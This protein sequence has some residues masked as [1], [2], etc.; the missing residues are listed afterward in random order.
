MRQAVVILTPFLERM[1]SLYQAGNDVF[2]KTQQNVAY[3]YPRRKFSL[4]LPSSFPSQYHCGSQASV[5]QSLTLTNR[6][7]PQ[8][9]PYD[10]NSSLTI[11]DPVLPP[12][13][14]EENE[15]CSLNDPTVTGTDQR[16]SL[17]YDEGLTPSV[18][19]D[20]EVTP[21]ILNEPE[22]TPFTLNDHGVTPCMLTESEYH[23]QTYPAVTPC[24]PNRLQLTPS[25]LKLPESNSV[26]PHSS[27]A[28]HIYANTHVVGES[29]TQSNSASAQNRVK[30]LVYQFENQLV[31]QSSERESSQGDEEA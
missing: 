8:L 18:F 19:A 13:E 30:A 28:N 27:T 7:V 10:P 17:Y 25:G 5:T 11:S 24:N 1:I 6:A 9:T 29:E 15:F 31:Q 14:N 4:P 23:T 16:V 3:K 12:V 21:C 2:A 20:Q 22:I 26:C